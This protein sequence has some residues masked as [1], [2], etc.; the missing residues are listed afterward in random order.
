MSTPTRC[1][2]YQY[3]VWLKCRTNLEVLN[4][5]MEENLL[6]KLFELLLININYLSPEQWD[7]AINKSGIR[8]ISLLLSKITRNQHLNECECTNE[9]M[10]M[11]FDTSKN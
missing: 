9:Y 6:R 5:T 4:N 1:N 7:R 8:R 11:T 3:Y 10:Y 2:V